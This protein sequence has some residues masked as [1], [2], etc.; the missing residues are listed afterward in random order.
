MIQ[1]YRIKMR[2]ERK[3]LVQNP[4]LALVDSVPVKLTYN[5]NKEYR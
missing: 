1:F 2:Y 5:V 3:R 4:E